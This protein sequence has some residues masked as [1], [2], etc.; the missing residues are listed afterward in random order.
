MD[1][2]KKLRGELIDIV[3]WAEDAADALVWK[4]PRHNNEIKNGAQLTVRPGQAA[5]FVDEGKIADV[6]Q[7]GRYR[8]ETA[9]LPILAT[10]K[11]WKYGFVS[12]FKVDV[13]FVSTRRFTDLKWGT[14][15]PVM[16]RDPEFGP[17]R[18]RAF[19]TYA[20]QV[21]DPA[22]IV[23]EVAGAG[24]HFTAD[25]ITEQ[26][27]NEIVSRFTDV[28]GESRIPVLDLAANYDELGKFLRERIA[29]GIGEYGLALVSLLVENISLPPN[30]EEALDKRSSMGIIG[31]LSRYTQ[32]QAAEAI[33]NAAKNPGGAAGE[34]MGLGAGFAMGQQMLASMQQASAQTQQQRLA[35]APTTPAPWGVPPPVPG[36]VAYHVAIAGQ[37]AGPF[38]ADELRGHASRGTLGPE[39]LVWTPGMAEWKRAAECPELL[40]VL[41]QGPPPMPAAAPPV[42]PVPPASPAPPV[43]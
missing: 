32:Y 41:D 28:L 31:D 9:N 1:W 26:L 16:L 4:F 29:P 40:R 27:R 23:S 5:V 15:N 6:F 3:E 42:P 36:V 12:P 13:Y 22:K 19:G 17:V 18:L 24:A 33:A 14:M 10:L 38:N 37:A 30:V 34:A 35:S 25:G 21:Q 11:G 43:P 7:P 2:I 8:L 39:T 20:M